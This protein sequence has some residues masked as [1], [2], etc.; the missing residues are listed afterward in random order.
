MG[1]FSSL[2]PRAVT[3]GRVEIG[4]FSAIAIGA[5]V[6]HATKIG[7][8]TVI[9][10]GATVVKS[11]PELVVAYGMLARIM[12]KRNP[13]DL[14]L[15]EWTDD[16]TSSDLQPE[17]HWRLRPAAKMI[18]SSSEWT[19][20]IERTK[21]ISFI[22]PNTINSRKKSVQSGKAWLCVYGTLEKFLAWPVTY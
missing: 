13:G 12:R 1:A 7:E 10:A 6:S 22:A 15:G 9:G 16:L 2:A 20:Y 4:A 18:P 8:H 3:G 17:P 14:Y 11:I 19:E 5:V 21:L